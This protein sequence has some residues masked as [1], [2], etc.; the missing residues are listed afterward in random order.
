MYTKTYTNATKMQPSNQPYTQMQQP[1]TELTYE[2]SHL[3]IAVNGDIEHE[4]HK[5]S[6]LSAI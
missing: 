3:S 1:Y 6:L 2:H 4:A 5:T